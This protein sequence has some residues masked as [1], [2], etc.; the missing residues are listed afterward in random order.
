MKTTLAVLLVAFLLVTVVGCDQQQAVDPD[1]EEE[2]LPSPNARPAPGKSAAASTGV[3]PFADT[4]TEDGVIDLG[5]GFPDPAGILG[6]LQVLD[7][8][9]TPPVTG[10][11]IGGFA[12]VDMGEG[13]EIK[14]KKGFDFL[15]V[16]ADGSLLGAGFG[17]PEPFTASVSNSPSGPFVDLGMANG[18][19]F[20]ELKGSGLSTARYVRLQDAN[21]F[22][23][24]GADIQGVV[25]FN[26]NGANL[27]L[28]PST[29][30]RKPRPR[31]VTGH[32]QVPGGFD[33]ASASIVLV[34]AIDQPSPTPP[35]YISTL[36]IPGEIIGGDDDD[37]GDDDGV[38]AAK[39]MGSA[40]DDDDDGD[41]DGITVRFDKAAFLDEAPDGDDIVVAVKLTSA[42][43][44]V[45]YL[46][47]LVDVGP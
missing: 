45:L 30:K 31:Y 44:E 14:N 6:N 24:S 13:E 46:F 3:D 2:V 4:V 36:D 16:E 42:S 10:L 29:I 35:P 8:A 12:V 23:P 11:G 37:D 15:V 18:N 39:Y 43:G 1:V 47:D 38:A 33:V 22:P 20:F 5:Q 32:L 19:G 7:P 40:D 9:K 26:H 34:A 27:R 25:A 41:D 17:V 21:G 28:T